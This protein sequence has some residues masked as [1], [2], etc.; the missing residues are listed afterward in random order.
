MTHHAKIISGGKIVIPAD[1][2]HALGMKDGDTLVVERDGDSIVLK[3]YAQV[4]KEVQAE[5]RAMLNKPFTVDEF[6]N[7]RR[8]NWGEAMAPSNTASPPVVGGSGL[9]RARRRSRLVHS[10]G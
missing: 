3:T 9:Y 10:H 4:V 8:A 5:F 1:L 6:L 2:R 7:E